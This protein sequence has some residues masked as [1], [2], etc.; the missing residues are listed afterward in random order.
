MA[1]SAG[2]L[3]EVTTDTITFGIDGGTI[4]YAA[5]HEFGLDGMPVRAFFGMSPPWVSEMA[6]AVADYYYT[7]F[8]E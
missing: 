7:I 5:K 2:S 3:T 4:D 8:A 6:E 1:T